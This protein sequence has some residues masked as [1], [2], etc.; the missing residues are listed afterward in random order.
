MALR[1]WDLEIFWRFR[2]FS[3]SSF[4]YLGVWRACLVWWEAKSDIKV[5]SLP[6]SPGHPHEKSEN[7]NPSQK[8][9]LAVFCIQMKDF[10]DSVFLWV[11]EHLSGLWERWQRRDHTVRLIMLWSKIYPHTIL[12]SILPLN[13][14]HWKFWSVLLSS[15][16]GRYFFLKILTLS[17]T[18]PVRSMIAFA[19][20]WL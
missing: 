2:F 12:W 8:G 13:Y 17:D 16:S 11:L 14:F 10:A 7:K 9:V 18:G 15:F 3:F 19:A 1:G 4:L 6:T 5:R 20:F